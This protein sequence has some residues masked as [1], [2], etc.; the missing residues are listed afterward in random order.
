MFF[1]GSRYSDAGVYQVMRADGTALRATHIPLPSSLPVLGWHRRNDTE[2]LDLLAHH[3][4]HDA[5]ATWR[6][7]WANDAMSLDAL[8]THQTIAIPRES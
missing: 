3:Y 6:L 1:P 4:L 2:R 5:T 8:A 7:G